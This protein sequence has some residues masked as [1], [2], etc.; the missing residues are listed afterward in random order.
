MST[1]SNILNPHYQTGIPSLSFFVVFVKLS[2]KHPPGD[3][4]P[5]S[6]PTAATPIFL[7]L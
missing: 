3:Y 1:G 6:L 4:Y 2:D 7:L 5:S